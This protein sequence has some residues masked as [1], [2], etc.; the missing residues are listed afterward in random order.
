[1]TRD[2]DDQ[3]LGQV[4]LLLRSDRV[5]ET[6][7]HR[8]ELAMEGTLQTVPSMHLRIAYETRRWASWYPLGELP[9]N[10]ASFHVDLWRI[11]IRFKHAFNSGS[12]EIPPG[13]AFH[14]FDEPLR[15]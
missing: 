6:P 15:S 4:D 14:F 3:W 1:M 13:D 12:R 7:E 5:L 2:Q 8:P 9:S 11:A 10:L